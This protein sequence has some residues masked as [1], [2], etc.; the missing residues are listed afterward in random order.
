MATDDTEMQAAA[1]AYNKTS[2]RNRAVGRTA[3][4]VL[5]GVQAFLVAVTVGVL[6]L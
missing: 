2:R 6:S 4:L 5:L 3:T 1:A